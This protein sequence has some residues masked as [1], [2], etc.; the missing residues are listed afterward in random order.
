LLVVSVYFC[1][2]VNIESYILEELTEENQIVLA[3]H[4]MENDMMGVFPYE[5]Q[6]GAGGAEA[7]LEP[8]FLRRVDQLE[9]FI[10]SQ[11]WIRKTLSVV[12]ILKEM[13]QAMHGGDPAYYR[14]PE[15]RE[16][17]A[18]Y[19][20][21]YEMSG[22]QEDL[23][24]LITTDHS[25]VRLACQGIDMGTRNFFRLK[26]TTEEKAAALFRTPESFHVTGRSLLA[27]R[28]LNNVIR[29]MLTSIFS[30][31]LIIF[32]S[33]ALLYRSF[34]VGLLSMLPNVIPLVFTMG[35]IGLMGLNL[36][37]ST[38]VTFAISLGIAVD[39]TIHYITRFREELVRCGDYTLAMY[40]TLK[41]AGR[42]IVLTTLIM[43]AGFLVLRV[44]E[45]RA[46][47]DFGLLASITLGSA[48]IGSLVFLPTAINLFKPWKLEARP[49]GEENQPAAG[50]P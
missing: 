26:G 28:A 1:T 30:A 11:P 34:K 16:L 6:V 3:N 39:D 19:L 27:Q 20:L 14:V 12:D 38:V 40:R 31:F 50:Q 17:V 29:D 10:A 21:L 44:S 47:Q 43:I 32:V 49:A 24:V 25:F 42:A 9:T 33:V 13:H 36:R 41:S 5:V 45:F 7:A 48:L 4:V 2:R 37:T 8:E 23:D 22:N 15:T 35:F 46:T 18:Q